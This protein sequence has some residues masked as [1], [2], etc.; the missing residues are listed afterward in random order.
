MSE[1]TLQI[2]VVALALSNDPRE[3]ARAARIHG[4][5]GLLF[6]AQSA[7]LD[8]P[9]LSESG[10]REFRRLLSS[11][12]RQLIGLRSD[13]GPKGFGPGADVDR[14]LARLERVMEAAV[15]LQAPLVCI[16]LGPLPAAP[17]TERPKPKVTPEMAGLIIIPTKEEAAAPPQPEPQ[18]PAPDPVFVS[19]VEGAMQELGRRA[20]RYSVVL[21][22]RSEL[23]SL[24]SLE[25]AVARCNCPW[26]GVDLDPVAVLEDEWS[27]DET[28]S[29]LGGLI[30]H[31]RGRDAVKGSGQRTRPAAIGQG[32]VNWSQILGDLRDSDYHGWISLDPVEL[33]DR[34][35]AASSGL[36][37]LNARSR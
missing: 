32:G 26:F 33:P 25:S 6:D 11:Q 36:E 3:A 16:D 24:A 5:A 15:G 31:V 27:V 23:A 20:D 13:L 34:A 22:F 35:A 21:A 2:G 8:L 14:A 12:D 28:F 4:F 37:F 29:R 9:E 10:R 7:A 17:R 18:T 30:R 19:Q 1:S